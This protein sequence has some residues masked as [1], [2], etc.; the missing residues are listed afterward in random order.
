[1]LNPMRK[2]G[3]GPSGDIRPSESRSQALTAPGNIGYPPVF[4]DSDDE[5]DEPFVKVPVPKNPTERRVST[6]TDSI[7]F[8]SRS[9]ISDS[10][11]RFS[12]HSPGSKR[13][14]ALDGARPWTRPTPYCRDLTVLTGS[15]TT[16]A[17]QPAVTGSEPLT[18]QTTKRLP[19]KNYEYDRGGS[20]GTSRN[21]PGRWPQHESRSSFKKQT[22]QK[23]VWD[24]T[25]EQASTSGEMNVG[26]EDWD[27][28]CRVW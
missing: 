11:T 2:S 12:S 1:M 14:S 17:S 15:P 20:G 27:D 4:S 6:L 21:H 9:H 3:A 5:D 24:V 8:S 22:H 13:N 26:R 23:P 10:S 25:L 19:M 16:N 18:F 7:R 28:G